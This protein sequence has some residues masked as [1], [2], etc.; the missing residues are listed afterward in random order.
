MGFQQTSD[1]SAEK[2][3]R[4]R[5]SEIWASNIIFDAFGMTHTERRHCKQGDSR[6]VSD[7]LSVSESTS[8]DS[9]LPGRNDEHVCC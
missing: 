4:L 1:M 5:I 6:D 9:G 2:S 7:K 8:I 3:C